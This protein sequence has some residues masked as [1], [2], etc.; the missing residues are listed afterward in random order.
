MRHVGSTSEEAIDHI[1]KWKVPPKLEGS[2]RD[3]REQLENLL[4][5][6]QIDNLGLPHLLV[7]LTEDDASE[8]RWTEVDDLERI[9]HLFNDN[10][11]F[12]DA[13]VE[14]ATLFVRRFKKL[15]EDDIL[16]TK[17]KHR[18]GGIFGRVVGHMVR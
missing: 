10:L 7:T 5:V 2:P 4:T 17:N 13:P 12:A 6:S 9:L 8:V 18:D 11:T 1:V 16:N 14:C 15:M 3:H